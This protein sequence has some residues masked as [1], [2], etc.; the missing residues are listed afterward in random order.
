MPSS[1][2]HYAIASEIAKKVPLSDRNMFFIGNAIGPDA[3]SHDD[4]TYKIAHFTETLADKSLKGVNWN[5]FRNEYKNLLPNDSFCLGYFC[6]LIQD[7]IWYH[8][9]MDERVRI[10]PKEMRK[11]IIM[12]K[13]YKD[14]NRLNYLLIKDFSLSPLSAV[15]TDSPVKEITLERLN[16]SIAYFSEW[17]K[18]EECS[19]SDLEMITDDIISAYIEKGTQIC[20]FEIEAIKNNVFDCNPIDF[21]VAP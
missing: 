13:V 15:F 10:Y 11:T 14:Y 6:H 4:G 7:A 3:S 2:I 18:T 8:D 20:I 19:P 9:F 5:A 16:E 12:Q 1:I 17:F 21:F